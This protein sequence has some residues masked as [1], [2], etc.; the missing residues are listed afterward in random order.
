MN[1]APKKRSMRAVARRTAQIRFVPTQDPAW[2]AL[3]R[4]LEEQ[5]GE[6]I[7]PVDSYL[8]S[9]RDLAGQLGI[10]RNTVS[11][12]Y[13]ALG[14]EGL[15]KAIH[16]RGV[17]VVR[18]ALNGHSSEAVLMRQIEVLVRA[19]QFYSVS[20]DWLMER[21]HE[22][23]QEAYRAAAKKI[24]FVECNEYD[25]QSL[26]R[27]LGKHLGIDVHPLLLS[28]LADSPTRALRDVD[29]L[30]TTFFH[31]G[32]VSEIVGSRH[33]DVVGINHVVSHESALA[34][35]RI[36]PGTEI[37]VICPNERTLDRVRKTVESLGRGRISAF[38]GM[39]R[40]GIAKTLAGAD[41]VV[42]AAMTHSIVKRERPDLETI[43]IKFNIEPRSIDYLRDAIRRQ[44]TAVVRA[45]R[46]GA[47]AKRGP[48]GSGA[49]PSERV[50]SV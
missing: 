22:A 2:E 20:R 15:L 24:A 17:R 37:A 9:V 10:N 7:Y 16:G 4:H 45:R 19:A 21:M 30:A 18:Q 42:D 50:G 47:R 49:V 12:A 33:V 39:D 31:L 38:A 44:R 26:G 35:A 32:E 3:R 29:L 36:K 48:R 28:D 1:A 6:G 13:Q 5:I 23:S 27:D 11:K 40:A 46:R 14:R 41:I 34:I 43:T 8:P 25:V